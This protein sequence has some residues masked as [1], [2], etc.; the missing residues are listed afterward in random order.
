MYILRYRIA[1]C[2]NCYIYICNKKSGLKKKWCYKHQSKWANWSDVNSPVLCLKAFRASTAVA[3]DMLTLRVAV[4]LT[5]V[6]L[7]KGI[8]TPHTMWNRPTLIIYLCLDGS[9][10]Y[11]RFHARFKSVINACTNATSIYLSIYLSNLSLL[12]IYLSI[13]LSQLRHIF[14]YQVFHIALTLT[15]SLSL[16]LYIYL[17][18]Y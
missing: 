8:R 18:I 1:E 7:R 16:S 17:Y 12:S 3:P 14:Q 6:F 5:H 11:R 15:L 13:Y 9:F 2:S 10:I 4:C